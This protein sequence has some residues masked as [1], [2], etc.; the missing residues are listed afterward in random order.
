MHRS[1]FN[2]AVHM[3]PSDVCVAS[4]SCESVEF[5]KAAAAFELAGISPGTR[6]QETVKTWVM[7]IAV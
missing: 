3:H 5:T 2:I 6:E 1:I 7:E 4:A